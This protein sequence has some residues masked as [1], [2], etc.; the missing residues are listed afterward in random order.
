MQDVAFI[1]V[2]SYDYDFLH[3][4]NSFLVSEFELVNSGKFYIHCF[5]T[6]VYL[7]RKYGDF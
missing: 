3:V 5:R 2:M 1:G 4:T 6:R 7:Y